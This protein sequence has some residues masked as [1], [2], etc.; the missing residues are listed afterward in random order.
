MTSG[1]KILF[2]IEMK[3]DYYNNLQCR[4][5]AITPSRSTAE[6]LRKR[7]LL[8]K[9]VGDKIIILIKV[10]PENPPADEN[11]PVIN[12]SPDDKYVFYL[13][14]DRSVF[15]TI[16]NVDEDAFRNNKRFYFS[17]FYQNELGSSKSLTK[18]IIPDPAIPDFNPGALAS[19]GTDIYECIKKTTNAHLPPDAGFWFKRENHQYVSLRD[20]MSFT[21]RMGSFTV[22]NA[23]RQFTIRVFG[24]DTL[25]NDLTKEIP[26]RNNSFSCDVPTTVVQTNLMELTPGRYKIRINSEEFEYFIDD[27]TVYD[28]VF[29]VIEI[30]SHLPNGNSFAFLDA[31]GKVKD[32]PENDPPEWLKYE[33]RFANRLA[34]W[35]YITPRHK[36][37]SIDAS[38]NYSFDPTPSGAGVNR[39]YFTSTRPI[40]L[41]ENSLKFSALLVV[42]IS[43]DPPQ[44]FPILILLNMA[45]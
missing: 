40:P 8:Y 44:F 25:T 21:T 17:N 24:F 26:I 34:Y 16:T 35:K 43:E 32:I 7:Q 13:N 22:V 2:M 23:A 30:F 39:N 4:D 19:D 14:L 29:G 6:L 11:K 37:D 3:H 10:K 1:Y 12:I 9:Q 38:P 36:I 15:T 33:I 27:D 31:L 20:M 42:P 45:C 28:N 41:T 18:K 5:F